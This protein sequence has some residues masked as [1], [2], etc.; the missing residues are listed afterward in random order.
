MKQ[1][2]NSMPCS[3]NMGF[4]FEVADWVTGDVEVQ[5][6]QASMKV[7]GEVAGLVLTH[8]C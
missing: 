1:T 4:L 8:S 6:A 3:E 5:F 7:Q 2:I